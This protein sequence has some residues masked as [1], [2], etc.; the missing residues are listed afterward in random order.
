MKWEQDL[1]RDIRFGDDRDDL[2]FDWGGQAFPDLPKYNV[3]VRDIEGTDFSKF[4]RGLLTEQILGYQMMRPLKCIVEIGVENNETGL[5]STSVF[6][7]NKL[8]DCIYLGIDVLDR[9]HLD[10]PLENIYTIQTYSQS[11]PAVH[12]ILDELGVDKIDILFIDGWH[13]INQVLYDWEYTTRLAE[14]GLVGFHDTA[15]HPGPYYFTHALDPNKWEVTPN[16]L[17]SFGTN[18]ENDYGIGF[19]RRK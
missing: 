8:K 16:L 12:K 2:D 6:F 4:D 13:S 1:V 15:Y 3:T 14:N 19:A 9:K 11:Y 5:T 17:Q 18:V 10:N 7:E